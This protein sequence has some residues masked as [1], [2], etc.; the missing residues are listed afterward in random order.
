MEIKS[1]ITI[2]VADFEISEHVDEFWNHLLTDLKRGGDLN[3]LTVQLNIFL[4]VLT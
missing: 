1:H 4:H 2:T 3:F